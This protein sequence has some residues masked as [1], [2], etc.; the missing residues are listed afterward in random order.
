MSSDLMETWDIFP[1]L[2]L[3]NL[4]CDHKASIPP[5]LVI[6]FL[7]EGGLSWRREDG[8]LLES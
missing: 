1:A 5:S 2:L 4:L 6:E 7:S 8:G 3:A